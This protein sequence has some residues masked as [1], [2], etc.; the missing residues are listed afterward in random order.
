M[1]WSVAEGIRS[2]FNNGAAYQVWQQPGGHEAELAE[3]RAAAQGLLQENDGYKQAIAERDAAIAERDRQ[4]GKMVAQIRELEAQR[5]EFY[6]KWI[7][8]ANDYARAVENRDRDQADGKRV[9]A[10]KLE[11]E[12]ALKLPCVLKAARRAAQVATHPDRATSDGERRVRTEWFQ[13]A[14]AAFDRIEAGS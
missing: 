5:N 13:K 4:M 3:I 12:A 2:G 8:C 11:L 9:K 7:G 10:E 1:P 6:Q 14:T